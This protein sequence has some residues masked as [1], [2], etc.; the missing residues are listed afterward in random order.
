MICGCQP[1]HEI[2]RRAVRMLRQGLGE[3]AVRSL[4]AFAILGQAVPL[5]ALAGIALQET[6]NTMAIRV[7]VWGENVHEQ[8][9]KVVARQ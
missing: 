7:T 9:N 5:S 8:K 2:R 6:G 1:A 4:Q 3:I